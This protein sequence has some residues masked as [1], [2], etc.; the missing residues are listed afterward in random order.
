MHIIYSVII[1]FFNI[2]LIRNKIE[3]E[4][5]IEIMTI[6]EKQKVVIYFS[7]QMDEILK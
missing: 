7:L 2:I 4:F 1:S 5:R 6:T 3:K